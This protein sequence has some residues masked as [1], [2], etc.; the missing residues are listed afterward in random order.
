[1]AEQGRRD[2]GATQAGEAQSR[3]VAEQSRETQWNGRGFLREL[4][5][6]N[7]RFDWVRG[8]MSAAVGPEAA[9]F[10]AQLR[11]F[12]EHAVDSVA[13]DAEGQYPPEV[14]D[15]LRVLG[16]FGMK[17]PK[18]YG[19]LGFSQLNYNRAVALVASHCASHRGVALRAPVHRRAAAAA[20]VRH[21][22]A[23]ARVAAALATGT[24][25]G[26]ALTEPGVGSD[27][28]PWPRRR[29]RG[30]RYALDPQ[31]REALVHE[32]L[33]PTLLVVMARTPPRS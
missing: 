19:G 22:G 30:R 18:E 16:A 29:S 11:E 21:G 26:F 2:S 24:I 20:A 4:F 17:I 15:G 32:R 12:L 10:H 5:L 31:R 13:I 6:G 28:A 1:M 27:P 7:F 23:E 9:E 33:V 3:A 14:I 25:S 8:P